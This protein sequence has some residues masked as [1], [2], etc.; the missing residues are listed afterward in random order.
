MKIYL[1]DKDAL[2]EQGVTEESVYLIP[3]L[4]L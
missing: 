2:L 4:L 3:D 1:A